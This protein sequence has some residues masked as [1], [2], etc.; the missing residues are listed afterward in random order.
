[1]ERILSV[2]TEWEELMKNLAGAAQVKRTVLK[3]RG[4][5]GNKDLVRFCFP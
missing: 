1:M 5:Y 3:M 4:K 2:I